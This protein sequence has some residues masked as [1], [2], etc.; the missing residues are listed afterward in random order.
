MLFVLLAEFVF[1]IYTTFFLHF[2]ESATARE[3]WKFSSQDM[4]LNIHMILGL[5]IVLGTAGFC[6]R[7]IVKKQQAWLASAVLALIGVV[8]ATYAGFM[9][10]P[11]QADSYSFLMGLGFAIAIGGYGWGLFKSKN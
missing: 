10:I 9:F 6:L 5:I 3:L 7:V 1:G 2:P 8:L 4:V 11:S